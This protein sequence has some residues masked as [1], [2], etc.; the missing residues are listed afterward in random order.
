[1]DVLDIIIIVA[2]IGSAVHGA[3]VGAVVQVISFIGFLTGIGI[4]AALVSAI[5]PHVDG[6][7][8][9]TLV[10]LALLLVPAA[11]LGGVGRTIGTRT[12]AALRRLRFG[13]VDAVA[14]AILAICGT[15]VV[16]WLFASI[17]INSAFTNVSDQIENSAMIRGIAAVLP[18]VPDAFSSVE[19]YLSVNGF[20]QVLVN[21]LPGSLAPVMTPSAAVV[22]TALHADGA[23]TVKII[24]TGCAEVES[25]GSGFAVGPGLVVTNAHV[26]AGTDHIVI[27]EPDGTQLIGHPV[28]FDD[29]FDLAVLRTAPLHLPI[30]S[31]A[32]SFAERGNDA[33]VLGYPGGGPLTASPAGI[34]TRF[35]AE[36]KDIYGTKTTERTVYAL[37]AIVRPGNS[38]GPLVTPSGTV[39]GVVFSRSATTT[40]LGYA[41]ASPGVAQRVAEAQSRTDTVGT[42]ACID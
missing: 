4:G 10:A 18:P 24:A 8:A 1:V 12:W 35:R 23:A 14:G 39:I 2:V 9:K 3:R 29:E 31:V 32:S 28:L 15:L 20:P 19:H 17:L 37:Q 27:E 42:G 21:A 34:L 41:L 38:G 30:L 26:I 5:N 7:L 16:C 11:V 13:P 36:G 33:V 40:D 6:Q 22:R 25:E